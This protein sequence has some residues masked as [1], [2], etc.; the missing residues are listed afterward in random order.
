MLASHSI[1]V[2]LTLIEKVGIDTVLDCLS[3]NNSQVQQS[4][5]TMI[6]MLI[7]ESNMKNIPEKV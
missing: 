4:M 2:F 7:N 3:T 1:N 5:L 6:A